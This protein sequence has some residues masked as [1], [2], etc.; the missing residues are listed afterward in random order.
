MEKKNY[1]EK[2]GA[3]N[4]IPVVYDGLKYP[5]IRELARDIDMSPEL[6]RYY[7]KNNKPINNKY[8]NYA[9]GES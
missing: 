6:I 4:A 9:I 3:H 8:I 7:L 2:R 5:S 1:I